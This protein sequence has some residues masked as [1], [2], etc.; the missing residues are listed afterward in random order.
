MLVILCYFILANRVNV[1]YWI[2]QTNEDEHPRK[3]SYSFYFIAYILFYNEMEKLGQLKN[4]CWD[5][6]LVCQLV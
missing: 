2:P 4:L 6:I 1:C 3:G 5:F